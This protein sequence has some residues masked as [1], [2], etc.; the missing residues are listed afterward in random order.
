MTAAGL[1]SS[2]AT[3]AMQT[4]PS[5]L[6]AAITSAAV[7]KAAPL[8]AVSRTIVQ[9]AM[10]T[11]QKLVAGTVFAAAIAGG[12][13]QVQKNLRQ[14]AELKDLRARA[15][16]AEQDLRL[17]RE[18]K[19][20]SMKA[21]QQMSEALA[22]ERSKTALF[23]SQDTEAESALDG[24]LQRV[25]S[26]KRFL[27]EHPKYQ[28]PELSLLEERDW[29]EAT[30]EVQ[31]EDEW[32]FR[33]A[34]DTLRRLAANRLFHRVMPAV[35]R[36]LKASKGVPPDDPSQ[37]AQFMNQPIDATVWQRYKI[38]PAG[39]AGPDAPTF[40]GQNGKKATWLLTDRAAV[41]DYYTSKIYVSEN[42]VA[43]VMKLNFDKE[44][45]A[46]RSAFQ[47]A[48]PNQRPTTAAQLAP[49]LKV[50]VDPAFVEKL[51]KKGP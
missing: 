6:N 21:L 43:T 23:A 10:T 14:E 32:D 44:V 11:T 31:L 12:I 4:A 15:A 26:M 37:F 9:I 16:S 17:L 18:Q 5:T 42:G 2:L 29:L 28:I 22:S 20:A 33:S 3:H 47:S 48:N 19:D 46:A 51:L 39:E 8:F 1:S 41:D 45:W 13:Y 38:I 30:K 25:V 49:Y 40:T 50:Q 24:W 7:V 34:A 27:K 35:S 36:Y